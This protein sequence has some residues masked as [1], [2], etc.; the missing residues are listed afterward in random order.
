MPEKTETN[1][2]PTKSKDEGQLYCFTREGI[3]V[4]ASSLEEAEKLYEKKL[5]EQESDNG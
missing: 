5:K 1:E 2:Q 3:N 4:R